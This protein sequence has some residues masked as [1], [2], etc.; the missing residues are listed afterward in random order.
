MKKVIFI[1]LSILV[2]GVFYALVLRPP[3]II[4]FIPFAI[5]QQLFRKII[6]EHVFILLFDILLVL[7]VAFVFN[8]YLKKKYINKK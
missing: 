7:L 2:G 8:I 1:L 3:S 6:S 4:N 5:H